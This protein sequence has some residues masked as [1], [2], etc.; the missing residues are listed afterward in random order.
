LC[1][2][3]RSCMAYRR[4]V[5]LFISCRHGERPLRRQGAQPFV[6][7]APDVGVQRV[8][9]LIAEVSPGGRALSPFAFRRLR[10]SVA[11]HRSSDF[12]QAALRGSTLR[13][14]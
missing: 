11:A 9:V 13:K 4:T 1:R 14:R 7:W 12:D 6:C 2:C 5:V 10:R 8:G 3:I